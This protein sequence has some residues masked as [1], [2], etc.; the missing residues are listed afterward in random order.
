MQATMPCL[1]SA[2]DGTQGSVCYR[3][4]RYRLS[5][6]HSH[7]LYCAQTHDL[8]NIF[9]PLFNSWALTSLFLSG[10]NKTYLPGVNQ[11]QPPDRLYSLYLYQL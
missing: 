7:S 2:E 11:G 4:A 9:S 10:M 8:S 1:Y 6:S 3:Q 5:H